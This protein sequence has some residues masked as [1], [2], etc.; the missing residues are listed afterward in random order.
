MAEGWG[1]FRDRVAEAQLWVIS[2][3]WGHQGCSW[4]LGPK[5]TCAPREAVLSDGHK[6]SILL[7]PDADMVLDEVKQVHH[8]PGLGAEALD[9]FV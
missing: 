3:R 5:P 4:V 8:V 6:L 9:P 7:S 1:P 2:Q